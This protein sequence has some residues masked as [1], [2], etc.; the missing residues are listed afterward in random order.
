M[1][2]RLRR[3]EFPDIRRLLKRDS[4]QIARIGQARARSRHFWAVRPST[5]QMNFRLCSAGLLLFSATLFL[6]ACG[7]SE[8]ARQRQ[9]DA[10]SPAGK[11]GKAA[12]AVARESEKVAR[13]AGQKLEKAAHQAHE[14][15]KE[16]AREDQAKDK[17]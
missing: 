9:E 5:L 4:A 6:D 17:K 7:P 11:A 14:G 12:H 3:S 13:V 10:N 1:A 15:W 8:S 16:A 2:A